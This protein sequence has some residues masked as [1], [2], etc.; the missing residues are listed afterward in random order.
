MTNSS[1]FLESGEIARLIPVIAD[2]RR[3]QRVTSVF[4][5]ALSAVPGFAQPLLSAI[6]VRLGKRSVI[7][8]YTE[9]VLKGHKNGKDRPDG[10][11]VVS[12][13]NSTWCLC[14]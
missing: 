2:S 11:I 5:A 1:D 3:E 4:L 14:S 12:S 8:T 13:G 6:G 7:D 10:L 9:V